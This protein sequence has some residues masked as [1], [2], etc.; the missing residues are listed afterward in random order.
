LDCAKAAKVDLTEVVLVENA[1]VGTF[2]VIPNEKRVI[3]K[4]SLIYFIVG[5]LSKIT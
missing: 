5:T 1:E 4:M 2:Y 3:L